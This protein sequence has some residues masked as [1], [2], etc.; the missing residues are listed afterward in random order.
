MP[1]LFKL[2]QDLASF[3]IGLVEVLLVFRF[4]LKLLAANPQA[5]FVEWV[6][7]NTQ[8]LLKPFLFAFPTPSVHGGFTLEFTT[9]FA[10]FTYAFAGYLIQEVLEMMGSHRRGRKE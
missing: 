2:L 10:I 8:P 1:S 7:V 9:L 4:V 5:G 3:I 6:Y